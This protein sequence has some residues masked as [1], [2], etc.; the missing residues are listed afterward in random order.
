MS[1]LR[2]VLLAGAI[3]GLAILAEG[4]AG[5]PIT[6]IMGLGGLRASALAGESRS[7][8]NHGGAP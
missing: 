2:L 8:L 3:L 4:F 1:V 7:G 6:R 5:L